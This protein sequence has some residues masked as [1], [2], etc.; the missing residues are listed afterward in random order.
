MHY[1]IIASPVGDLLAAGDTDGLHHLSFLSGRGPCQPQPHWRHEPGCFAQLEADLAAYFA[2]EPVRFSIAPA[3]R[4][5]AFRQRVWAALTAIPHGTVASY[6]DI[7]RHIG[8]PNSV[9]AVG[10]ANGANPV[11]IVVPCHRVVGSDG[12]LTGYAGGL[13]IKRRLLALEGIEVDGRD[14]VVAAG[15]QA[16]LPLE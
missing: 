6:A 11:A 4:G 16:A 2:G 15:G 9:R 10:A 1:D 7:A 12:T 14:R 5:T 8:N 13:D 3:G